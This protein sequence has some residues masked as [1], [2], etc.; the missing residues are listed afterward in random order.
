MPATKAPSRLLQGRGF[1]RFARPI[2]RQRPNGYGW[3][4]PKLGARSR[5]ARSGAVLR[6]P[7]L[8]KLVPLYDAQS[9]ALSEKDIVEV[10]EGKYRV[11]GPMHADRLQK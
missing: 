9:N 3:P 4:L 6:P 11:D 2:T 1:S 8:F 7:Q 5:T 10:A